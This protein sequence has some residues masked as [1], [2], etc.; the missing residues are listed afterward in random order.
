MRHQSIRQEALNKS[1]YTHKLEFEQPKNK[2]NK[3]IN[4]KRNITWFNPPY[5]L[6][7]KTNVGKEFLKLVDRS[8]PPD[9]PL[10]KLFNR[11]TVKLGYKCMPNMKTEVSRHNSKVLKEDQL[12]VAEKLEWFTRPQLRRHKLE[13][14]RHIQVL[15]V[16]NS[17]QD[18]RSTKLILKNHKIGPA[19][20]SAPIF[21]I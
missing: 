11:Q 9:N 6:S 1:G 2:T 10:H 19:P 3:N 7:V 5:S 17:S 20:S 4:R 13:G 15:L 18:G 16:E 12:Q 8:F 14:S 21:G